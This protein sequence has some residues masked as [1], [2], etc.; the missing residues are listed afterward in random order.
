MSN[1]PRLKQF[2]KT[3]VMMCPGVGLLLSV[4]GGFENDG[5]CLR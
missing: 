5:S 3:A 1:H 4:I 2:L